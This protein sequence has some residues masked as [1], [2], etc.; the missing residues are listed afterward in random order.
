[1]KATV[2]GQARPQGSPRGFLSKSGKIV[3]TEDTR[4]NRGY[5][6]W[7]QSVSLEMLQD[8]PQTPVD[9]PVAV[10]LRIYVP[11]PKAH[12]GT[13]ANSAKLKPTAPERPATGIDVDKIL[14]AVLDAGTGIWW[15]DDKRVAEIERLARLY[16]DDGPERIEVEARPL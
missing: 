3:V 2:Y 5:R 8:A 12:F 6:S 7:R 9:G 11:R 10:S 16:A 13:G 4:G 1:V 14:R 15:K